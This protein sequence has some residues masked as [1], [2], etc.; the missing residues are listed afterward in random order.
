MLIQKV[1]PKI[2]H[3]KDLPNVAY[4]KNWVHEFWQLTP[5]KD[6]AFIFL[7]EESTFL[8]DHVI[9]KKKK[10]RKHVKQSYKT[11]SKNPNEKNKVQLHLHTKKYVANKRDQPPS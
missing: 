9:R 1:N 10:K 6:F 2:I 8:E 7:N 5:S 3:S 11:I 4:G